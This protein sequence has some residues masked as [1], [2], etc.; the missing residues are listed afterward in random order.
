MSN[1]KPESLETLLQDFYNLTDIKACLC[2]LKGN[3][4]CFYPNKL[5]RF[6]EI[7][8]TDPEMD[9]KCKSCDAIAF[10]H[11]KK[12]QSQHIYTCHA[13]LQECIS[14]ILCDNQVIG[15]IM[16]GQIKKS[17]RT[18]FADVSKNLPKALMSKLKSSY[19]SLPIISTEKLLSAFRILDACA[20]YELLKTLIQLDQHP[21]DTQIAQYVHNHMTSHLSV[22]HL[23]SEFRLS[24]SEIYHIFKEY[25]SCTPAE[26]VKKARL[27]YACKLLKATELP[28]N[29][30]AV[31]CG[32]PDYN[33]FSKIFKFRYGIS[34][35][36]YRKS[37]NTQA[38]Q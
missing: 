24:R 18:D 23:C 31:Q 35:T 25:Y 9:Q 13:G 38:D 27:T 32:I 34:P 29:E 28:V 2:D 26:Y 37:Q 30:I 4:L 16:I 5:S 12:T 15:F 20:G 7:L 21:I 14:P 1:F 3:E 17:N 10:A 33:Y 8:R 6:C 11:C 22:T 19:D 36:G